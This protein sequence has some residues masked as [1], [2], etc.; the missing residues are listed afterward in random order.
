MSNRCTLQELLNHSAGEDSSR[1]TG[2]RLASF[3]RIYPSAEPCRMGR[4]E[5]TRSGRHKVQLIPINLSGLTISGFSTMWRTS[6]G[7]GTRTKICSVVQLDDTAVVKP[8]MAPVVGHP[9]Q[10]RRIL[11]GTA[12]EHLPGGWTTMWDDARQLRTT[13]PSRFIWMGVP[14]GRNGIRRKRRWQGSMSVCCRETCRATE[15]GERDP[16]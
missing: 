5:G 7:G 9:N 13:S 8:H 11:R 2:S 1:E 4:R 6:I 16:R 12:R 3:S 15:L 10:Q 14:T